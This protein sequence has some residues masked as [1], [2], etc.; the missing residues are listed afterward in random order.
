VTDFTNLMLQLDRFE[1]EFAQEFLTRLRDRTPVDTGRLQ[2][3]WELE[4][5]GGEFEV[6]NPVEYAGYVE[7]GTEH[8][9]PRAML[10]TTLLEVDQIADYAAK[11]VGLP[12]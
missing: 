9:A 12:Q 1:E 3:G 5:K 8:M 6:R 11:K 10:A 2:A 4:V 7:Y